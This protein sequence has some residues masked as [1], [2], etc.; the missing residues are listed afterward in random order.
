MI[1]ESCA[2]ATVAG[3]VHRDGHVVVEGNRI[4]AVGPGRVAARA[5]GSTPPACSPRP[6]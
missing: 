3:A 5:S 1:I 2:V 4:T 6:G